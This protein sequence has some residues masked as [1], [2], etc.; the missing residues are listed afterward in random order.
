M[1]TTDRRTEET[2]ITGARAA[3]LG[4]STPN[5]GATREHQPADAIPRIQ[6][7]P[8]VLPRN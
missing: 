7:K 4:G 1:A 2:L 5:A 6:L 3:E 8:V